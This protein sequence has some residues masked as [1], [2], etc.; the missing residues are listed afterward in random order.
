MF[1]EETMSREGEQGQC[2]KRRILLFSHRNIYDQLVWRCPFREFERI[3]QEVDSVDVLAPEPLNWYRHGRRI[4]MR[5]GE[6]VN[7]PINPGIPTIKVER[8]YDMFITVCE[9]VSELLHLKSL[10]GLRDKCK[11]T[12]C[13]LPEFYFKDIPVYKSC[14]E[15]L[16]QFD[17]VIFMFVA[18]EPFRSIIKGRSQY[19]PAGIDTLNFCPHP[20]PPTRSID[21]LSIGRRAPAT[22]KALMRMAREDEKFYVYDT[23]N[24]LKAYDLDE[25]RLMMANMAKRSRYFIVS[26]GK[27]DKPE[28]TGG[29]SEFG[30]RYFEAA[31]AG[32]IMI[33]M[34]PFNNKEFDKI[35]TWQDAI[36]EVPFTSD[37]IVSVI[38]QFDKEPE[39]QMKVRQTNIAQCLLNHDWVY[40]WEAVLS[41]V[42]MQPLPAL[43]SRKRILKDLAASVEEDSAKREGSGM[44]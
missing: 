28:E 8:E 33:G 40:R 24:A 14:I 2:G 16:K 23:I 38:R 4:A 5:L 19:L 26:P 25:H 13:W 9:R 3:L 32:T 37:E 12:V 22:H 34:R 15:V 21:V 6:F 18:N 1:L 31:A 11:T 27:F 36:L 29:T 42:G 20:N 10:K 30:Y 43:Q 35:F 44:H 17:Y 7:L 41:L 39:R